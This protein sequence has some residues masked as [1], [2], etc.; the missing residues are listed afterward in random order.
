MAQ[1]SVSEHEIAIALTYI[2][3]TDRDIWLKV[4]TAIKTEFGEDGFAMFDEWSSTAKNY[5]SADAK[6]AWKSFQ[7]GTSNIG[8]VI[9]RAKENGFVRQN[10]KPMSA[11]EIEE[12]NRKNRE[13]AAKEEQE[14]AKKQAAASRRI[15]WVWE[16]RAKTANPKHPYLVKKGISDPAVLQH[17]RQSGDNL[18]IPLKQ[19]KEVV[20]MQMIFP[21]GRKHI[22]ADIPKRGS[23]LFLG[24]TRLENLKQGF[25]VAEGFAT[26]ASI[27]QATGRPCLMT[28]DAGN[29]PTVVHSLKNLVAKHHIPVVLCAD[30]D[31]D[32]KGEKKAKEAAEILGDT[33]QV[34]MPDFT[35]EEIARF[36][37]NNPDKLP[38]DFNDLQTLRGID[39][40][41]KMLSGSLTAV[42][43][44]ENKLLIN[45]YGS[46]ATGKSY[47]AEHLA[48]MLKDAGIECELVTE[49]ATEL[50]HQGRTD[51]LK[52]QVVVTGE[53]LR[54]EQAAL[55]HA[56]IVITDSPTALGIIYA[57]EHQKA[58]LHD[59]AAQSDKIPHINILLRHDYES[60]ATFSMNGRIHDKEQSLAIQEQLIEL[61]KGK[62][63]IHHQR[64][65]PFEE[66][67]NHIGTNQEWQ[68]FAEHHNI[69]LPRFD[70][71]MDGTVLGKMGAIE[72]D[73]LTVSEQTLPKAD[74]QSPSGEKAL[75]PDDE[76]PRPP[77]G[78]FSLPENSFRQPEQ[79]NQKENQMATQQDN[80]WREL[81]KNNKNL[82]TETLSE[83]VE[84]TNAPDILRTVF[85]RT[86][87]E[88]NNI[89]Q[90]A[91]DKWVK[92][93]DP[94]ALSMQE[95]MEHREREMWL[96]EQ[97]D[98]MYWKADEYDK[99]VKAQEN[100]DKQM[101]MQMLN[102]KSVS[103]RQ[104][105]ATSDLADDEVL[106]KAFQDTDESVRL[107]AV[108]NPNASSEF[109]QDA[110]NDAFP[111]EKEAILN[112]P[113]ANEELFKE[114]LIYSN[115]D[116]VINIAKERLQNEYAW[117][118]ERFAALE[119]ERLKNLS[120][121]EQQRLQEESGLKK[122][123]LTAAPPLEK[124]E[125]QP[126]TFTPDTWQPESGLEQN[127]HL[128]GETAQKVDETATQAVDNTEKEVSGSPEQSLEPQ[129]EN[130]I[131]FGDDEI[132]REEIQRAMR[133]FQSPEEKAQAVFK[134]LQQK[135]GEEYGEYNA[136]TL[137]LALKNAP[138]GEQL[139]FD[140]S[141]ERIVLSGVNPENN[142]RQ[143]ISDTS[144]KVMSV[145]SIAQSIEDGRQEHQLHSVK[146]QQFPDESVRAKIDEKQDALE[147]RLM[148][149]TDKLKLLTPPDAPPEELGERYAVAERKGFI[150]DKLRRHRFDDYY[151][152][153][154]DY[155]DRKDGKTIAF[156]DKGNQLSTSKSD[157]QT[158]ADMLQV[159]KAKGW[160][161]VKLRGSKEFKRQ[162][163]IEAAAMGLIVK[164][165][166]P[167]P[168]D[169]AMVEARKKELGVH[170][171]EEHK[172]QSKEPKQQQPEKAQEQPKT[173]KQPEPQQQTPQAAI[174][175]GILLAHGKEHYH[176]NKANKDSYFATLQ[177]P[178]GTKNTLWGRDIERAIKESGAEVGD[179]VS[180]QKLGVENVRVREVVR[181]E[182]GEPILNADGVPKTDEHMYQRNQY[183][184]TIHEK[185]G[186]KSQGLPQERL[187]KHDLMG[188]PEKNPAEL[189]QKVEKTVDKDGKTFDI[190]SQKQQITADMKQM[191]NNPEQPIGV[192]N[193]QPSFQQVK[194]EYEKVK[195]T[196]LDDTQ[197]QYLGVSERYLHKSLQD[198]NASPQYKEFCLCN[199]YRSITAEIKNG[200]IEIPNPYQS[201]S[202]GKSRG[203][204]KS[205]TQTQTKSK[206][207][208]KSKGVDI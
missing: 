178:D 69:N 187:I 166:S 6:S 85:F 146:T 27:V 109:L 98:E 9:N 157:Q 66:L 92:T 89:S 11:A 5:K 194:D 205:Q 36:Q 131:D 203:M 44:P 182:Q 168:Q 3:S 37:A 28:I 31:E 32:H 59:I 38:S 156:S 14:R 164:G 207:Q 155:I 39:S 198:C 52:D 70:I 15:K 179:R 180:L 208:S 102:N 105:A 87:E 170:S 79:I 107:A 29:M 68:R 183:A 165:Y 74:I 91:F 124:Q 186:A 192:S 2:D 93:G 138:Y 86:F 50:I 147:K 163:Y 77:Q 130:H 51:E 171:I 73:T 4:G 41:T 76:K 20:G 45:V 97:I 110:F 106:Q 174:Q 199:F 99:L 57:P 141:Q 62:E 96:D 22:P 30:N 19:G 71:A 114:V 49:Y 201:N 84:K 63:R 67:I 117:D 88:S 26:A 119:Q 176:F 129:E 55:N 95:D 61:L 10:I 173:E 191:F 101:L 16:N 120:R 123:E 75:N 42:V 204:G 137:S 60:L 167:T 23:A 24:D 160:N 188:Q 47:T 144:I 35:A 152:K 78:G 195:T 116:S 197:R 140:P 162:A 189:S 82:P 185:S 175:G 135:Y 94:E 18:I 100:P 181:D 172:T 126:D 122:S 25:F 190:E 125:W 33:A 111:P 142:Q 139:H 148:S 34:I 169:L 149:G 90:V 108:R 72:N 158:I 184:V 177:N 161:T 113:N 151:T 40:V 200:T 1:Y 153:R 133:S 115:D 202:V 118:D 48:A 17:I 150:N 206:S 136:Q 53:Q 196:H 56:N 132:T 8:F 104:M 13:R 7:I 46:P 83:I 193:A 80:E 54:R 154:L 21:N 103:F 65:T 134:E 12:R 81:L 127:K 143:E 159:A 58:A 121:Y 128:D 145:E 64:A 112:H 43:N